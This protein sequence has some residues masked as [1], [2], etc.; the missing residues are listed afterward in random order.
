MAS[1]GIDGMRTFHEFERT[2]S[3]E[4]VSEGEL[5]LLE[6]ALVSCIARGQ[7][8]RSRPNNNKG[9]RRREISFRCGRVLRSVA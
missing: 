8:S 3:G 6:Q 4:F 2:Q 5:R 9:S 7:R 1:L